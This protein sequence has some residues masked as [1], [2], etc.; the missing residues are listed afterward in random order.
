MT[1]ES[2]VPWK[3]CRQPVSRSFSCNS[4]NSCILVRLRPAVQGFVHCGQKV[5]E[6]TLNQHEELDREQAF[7]VCRVAERLNVSDRTARRLIEAGALKAYRIGRQWRVFEPDL[8][9]YLARQANRHACR[10][11]SAS[12]HDH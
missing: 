3:R 9:E 10:H 12:R 2:G 6:R 8:E 5:M 11:F 4:C 1:G 7:S